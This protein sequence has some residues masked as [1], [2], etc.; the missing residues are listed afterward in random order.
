[1]TPIRHAAD[2][3]LVDA[4]LH[5]LPKTE[6][7][8]LHEHLSHCPSCSRR[9]REWHVLLHRQP[10]TEAEAGKLKRHL[11]RNV[12]Q[13]DKAQ[14]VT[15]LKRLGNK[16]WVIGFSLAALA[17]V[18]LVLLPFQSTGQDVPSIQD[19]PAEQAAFIYDPHT[20]QYDVIP[21]LA[22]DVRGDV[23]VNDSTKEMLIRVEGLVP[24]VH[25]DYQ[26]WFVDT[27]DRLHGKVL[28]LQNGKAVLYLHGDGIQ[29]IQSL[30][31]SLEPKGGSPVPTGAETF[32]VD[33]KR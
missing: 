18:A 13:R 5:N 29:R 27:D 7:E 15:T 21:L 10:D 19:G 25:K 22:A 26:L 2:E 4:I 28:E 9:Y 12:A 16:Q 30:R 14:N 1:M 32:I 24:M 6:A 23:W 11:M 20:V 3:Q 17:V 8:K 31:T 33:L